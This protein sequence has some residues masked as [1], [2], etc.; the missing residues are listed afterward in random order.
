[1]SKMRF[2]CIMVALVL[3][4]L[5]SLSFISV[6]QA[7]AK[8]ITIKAISAW[9][10]N[11]AAVK[12]DY[13]AFIN[14]TNEMLKDKYPGQIEIR[15]LGGPEIIPIKDQPEALRVGTVQMYFGTDAYYAGIAPAAN[16]SKLTQLFSWEER[17]RGVNAIYDE[18]HRDK[19][20]A[21]YLGR[22]GGENSF[23][24]YL[25]KEVST[26][27]GLKGLRIRVSPMYIDFL[28]A[29]G[30][31]PIE[32]SPGDIYQALE[33]GVVDGFCW[34]VYSIRERGWHEVTKYVVGPDFYKVAHPVL[35][36][37]DTWNQIPENMQKDIMDI[38]E[39]QEWACVGRDMV[40]L[41]NERGILKQE[42]LKFISFSPEETKQYYDLAYSS[43]WEA[44]FKKDPVYAPKLRPL[45][46]R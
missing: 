23:Q 10:L 17:E 36:N 24:L 5:L 29:L 8:K 45:L 1:M 41:K 30:V 38:F 31:T 28:K 46:T 4:S 42:G 22:I 37:V 11:D 40:K 7:A 33:R 39:A 27:D 43:A 21:T 35:V 16:V 9:G 25:N 20:N 2:F 34:P 15:Y 32:T 14:A 6:D 3:C 19:L 12:D 13:V 44:Q 26:L 18:I